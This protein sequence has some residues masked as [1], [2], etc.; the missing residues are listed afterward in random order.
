MRLS[1]PVQVRSIIAS[2]VASIVLGCA[3][4]E[5]HAQNT[6]S[7]ASALQ[8]PS[9]PDAAPSAESQ[10]PPSRQPSDVQQEP[11]ANDQGGGFVF[12]KQVEEVILH[13]T[14]V[15]EHNHLVTNL[16]QN[17]FSVFEDGAPQSITSFRQ[18]DVPVAMGI[19]IDNSGSMRDKRASV[20]EAVLNL[21]RTSNPDDQ[22][23]VVNFG[24]DSYLDQDFTSNV[25]LLQKAL[26]AVSMRGSTALYDAVVA[27]SVHLER[28]ARLD[29]KVLLVITDGQDNASQETLQDATYRLQQEKKGPAL[30]AIGIL[31]NDSRHLGYGALQSLANSTGGIA[32]FPQTLEELNDITRAVAHD[33]RSQYTIGYKPGNAGTGYRTIRV[34]AHARGYR[35]LSVRTRTGYYP[36]EA[37]H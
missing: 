9:S 30:Y 27:S 8:S 29:K 4:H 20:N 35:K 6:P 36:G 14:V 5:A 37:V 28:S 32:F 3:L 24:T 34:E 21:I 7:S 12:K 25:S 31:G 17:A 26:Q 10:Q 13:A 23:F 33:V 11:P 22:I 2:L 19:V 15:D 18:E 16:G 1:L